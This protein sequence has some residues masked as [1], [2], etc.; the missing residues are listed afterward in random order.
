MVLS[1][2]AGA[3]QLMWGTFRGEGVK[4][5]VLLWTIIVELGWAQKLIGTSESPRSGEAMDRSLT[6]ATRSEQIVTVH[7]R[8]QWF[9]MNHIEQQRCRNTFPYSV[10]RHQN[11]L[12]RV[13]ETRRSHL[14]SR[15]NIVVWLL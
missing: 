2:S 15:Q 10:R 14:H 12:V 5:A 3:A 1:V 11:T 9:L 8:G 13:C 6:C 7:Q 4:Y